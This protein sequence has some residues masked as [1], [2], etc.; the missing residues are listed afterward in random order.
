M[1]KTVVVH[2]AP[3]KGAAQHTRTSLREKHTAPRPTHI[4]NDIANENTLE[5]LAHRDLPEARNLTKRLP[6]HPSPNEAGFAVS[7]L[8][9]GT[10]E[11]DMLVAL[12]QRQPGYVP[13]TVHILRSADNRSH[14]MRSLHESS[15]RA[16]A[17]LEAKLKKQSGSS[18]ADGL[19]AIDLVSSTGGSDARTRSVSDDV[20][21]I[22]VMGAEPDRPAPPL[23]VR[24]RTSPSKIRTEVAV[25]S[26][27]DTE[28]IGVTKAT[29]EYA[30]SQLRFAA[31]ELSGSCRSSSSTSARRHSM[32]VEQAGL[33]ESASSSAGKLG[34]DP[35]SP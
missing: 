29:M 13:E 23:T 30:K 17:R 9:I 16:R 8:T 28:L 33:L 3:P 19:G 21:I 2:V 10:L 34:A 5:A 24:S 1:V 6:F 35:S 18:P 22:T 12:M 20:R 26:L 27:G 31:A 15:S 32:L 11:M 25:H 4:A 14:S 7:Y